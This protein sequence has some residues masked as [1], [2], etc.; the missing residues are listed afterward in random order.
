[1]AAF[2]K[3]NS[4]CVSVEIRIITHKMEKI[5]LFGI[6]DKV[7]DSLDLEVLTQLSPITLNTS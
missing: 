5:T 1:M 3:N 2:Y 4:Y 7:S 6:V